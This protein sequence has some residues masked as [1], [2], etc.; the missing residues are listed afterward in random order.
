MKSRKI[1]PKVKA[2]G[3]AG[4]VATVLL[5]IASRLH[6]E[7][8]PAEAG[9]LATLAFAAAGYAKGSRA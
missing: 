9:A 3:A 6:F 7:L 1:H 8:S 4:A 2:G 5:G